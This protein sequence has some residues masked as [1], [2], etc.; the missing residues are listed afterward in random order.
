MRAQ[1]EARKLLKYLD[2][3]ELP[4]SLTALCE[5]LGIII[6]YDALTAL[7]GYFIRNPENKKVLI[8]VN[9]NVNLLRQRFSV[10]HEM[11]HLNLHRGILGFSGGPVSGTICRNKIVEAEANYFASE[12]L[13][14]KFLLQNCGYMSAEKIA[15][16][17]QVS[18]P[19]AKIRAEHMGWA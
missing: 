12:L 6:K 11:G 8:V 9:D 16:Y 19:A 13:M 10:A 3:L 18:L 15:D 14:P 2:V 17:C 1:V 5:R 4:I 7:D